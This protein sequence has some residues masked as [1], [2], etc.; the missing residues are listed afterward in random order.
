MAKKTKSD[1]IT[2]PHDA[3]FKANLSNKKKAEISLKTHLPK[4]LIKHV[5]FSSLEPMPT[6]FIKHTLGKLASDMLYKVQIKGKD[7]YFYWLFE[8][9]SSPDYLMPFRNL[10]YEIQIMQGHLDAGNDKLPIVITLVF[11]HGETSPYPYSNSV[12]DL[13]EDVELAKKYAFNSFELIDL[14]VMTK[15]QMAQLNPELLF[16][17]LLKYNK[18]NLIKKLTEWLINNPNQSLYFLTSSK[19][20]LNQVLSYIEDQDKPNKKSVDKLIKVINQNTDGEFMNYLEKREANAK[21][22]GL[23]QGAIQKA[24]ETARNLIDMGLDDNMIAKATGLEIDTV[25][26]LRKDVDNQK[27]R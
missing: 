20:L 5:D 21:K 6:E 26:S 16:E 12:Y 19:K 13:F 10:T 24:Q 7:A 17:F 11:Y 18:E 3:L 8:H 27:K 15:E 22:Q 1:S 9:Q 23:E 14:T 2:Q 25:I 4:S